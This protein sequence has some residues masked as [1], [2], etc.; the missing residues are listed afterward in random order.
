MALMK[1]LV[2]ILLIAIAMGTAIWAVQAVAVGLV[3]IWI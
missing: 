1:S 2:A 3:N